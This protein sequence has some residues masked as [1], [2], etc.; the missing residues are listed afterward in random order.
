MHPSPKLMGLARLRRGALRLLL[1]YSDEV[2]RL[3]RLLQVRARRSRHYVFEFP[4]DSQGAHAWRLAPLCEACGF[5]PLRPVAAPPFRGRARLY[6]RRRLSPAVRK[7]CGRSSSRVGE[8]FR[9]RRLSPPLASL[10]TSRR[11]RDISSAKGVARRRPGCAA[12]PV[13]AKLSQR[14]PR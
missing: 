6:S 13:P 2:C 3:R 14:A 11:S 4:S 7:A 9:S 5:R 8:G 1:E 12:R 10:D